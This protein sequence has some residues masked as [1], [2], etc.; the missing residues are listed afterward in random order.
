M[1]KITTKRGRLKKK[2]TK[3]KTSGLY[4][5]LRPKWRI[6][7]EHAFKRNYA[8]E[9]AVIPTTGQQFFTNAGTPYTI[10]LTTPFSLDLL[11]N[12]TEFENL[13]DQFK[14]TGVR[15]TFTY[16]NNVSNLSSN[17][18]STVAG[19]NVALPFLY[20]CYDIDDNSLPSNL[21][22]M[23]QYESCKSRRLDRPVKVWVKPRYLTMAYASAISTAYTVGDPKRWIDI[24]NHET[25]HYGVKFCLDPIFT[26][27]DNAI[28]ML[29]CEMKFYLLCRGVR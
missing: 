5:G 3:Y 6:S 2:I 23:R 1:K 8:W 4:R 11:P 27:S 17:T 29:R 12:Y 28:G 14:I 16:S 7:R 26:V 9:A 25:P 20:W 24:A 22:E 19:A 15:M 10:S 18:G 21:N 13:Y